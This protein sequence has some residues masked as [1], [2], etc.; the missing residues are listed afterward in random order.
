MTEMRRSLSFISF[1][2]KN[3]NFKIRA[4]FPVCCVFAGVLW[5]NER[6]P[7]VPR[8]TN[9]RP[10]HGGQTRSD[11]GEETISQ[12]IQEKTGRRHEACR[13]LH[14]TACSETKMAF[15]AWIK[16]VLAFIC[17]RGV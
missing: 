17:I 12:S 8:W 15:W 16:S 3:A 4:S 5:T 1:F 6:A 10:R 2:L 11:G 13:M 14:D 9:E 7:C